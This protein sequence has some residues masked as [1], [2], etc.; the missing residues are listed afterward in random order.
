MS[1]NIIIVF[2]C[3]ILA[4]IFSTFETALIVSNPLII[5]SSIKKPR[6]LRRMMSLF[7]NK[8]RHI[9]SLVINLNIMNITITVFTLAIFKKYFGLVTAGTISTVITVFGLL[10]FTEII[11]KFIGFYFSRIIIIYFYGIVNICRIITSPFVIILNRINHFLFEKSGQK[12]RSQPVSRKEIKKFFQDTQ[13]EEFMA[14]QQLMSMIDHTLALDK[15]S[16]NEC[17]NPIHQ[18]TAFSSSLTVKEFKEEIRFSYYTRI[19]IFTED[20]FHITGYVLSRDILL[21]GRDDEFI[22]QYEYKGLFF[23]ESISVNKAINQMEKENIPLVFSVDEF[24]AVSGMITNKDLNELIIGSFQD[25]RKNEEGSFS[26][27]E[28]GNT[29]IVAGRH[30][31]DDLNSKLGLNIEKKGFETL[32]GFLMHQISA[33]PE[34]GDSLTYRGFL[35]TVI[36]KRGKFLSHRVSIQK[37]ESSEKED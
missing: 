19:P 5:Y 28:K 26:I 13:E 4:G 14:S 11:P 30:D 2:L 16:I 24:G 31:V 25:D 29:W 8:N 7:E 33:I 9:N 10:I 35:Y 15:I 1:I 6:H 32:G 12:E 22:S 23:P 21:K 20:I 27:K 17:K 36:K 3:Y 18:L 34:K 37:M